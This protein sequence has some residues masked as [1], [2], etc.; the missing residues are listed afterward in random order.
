MDRQEELAKTVKG[1]IEQDRLTP[2]VS[3]G[4]VST[5]ELAGI[6]AQAV[7]TAV[8]QYQERSLQ[9]KGGKRP[10]E[11]NLV[12]VT[13]VGNCAKAPNLRQ[14][15]NQ[16]RV[17]SRSN[18]IYVQGQKCQGQRSQ[19]Q[20][21][22]TKRC[23]GCGMEDHKRKS[24]PNQTGDKLQSDQR[25]ISKLCYKCVQPGH[26]WMDC[27][28]PDIVFP[29]ISPQ[30]QQ[31]QGKRETSQYRKEG[32]QF[33]GRCFQCG[34]NGHRRQNCPEKNRAPRQECAD[35]VPQKPTPPP[36]PTASVQQRKLQGERVYNFPQ[37]A[38]PQAPPAVEGMFFYPCYYESRFVC[39]ECNALFYKL[40][41]FLPKP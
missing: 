17:S 16:D 24:C 5:A 1:V 30:G 41:F 34:R 38:T 25:R 9:L 27:P 28:R 29:Q 6:V 15:N 26:K 12:H 4:R 32:K 3:P 13:D 36:F 33:R 14:Q 23:F 22:I 19:V 37:A 8:L 2:Q 31:D 39:Y 40:I 21:E 10:R 18:E 7:T 35:N 11:V 20:N